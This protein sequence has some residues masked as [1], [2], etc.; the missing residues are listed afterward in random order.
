MSYDRQM[1]APISFVAAALAMA[2]GLSGVSASGVVPVRSDL[3]L[4]IYA[5]PDRLVRLPDGRK[6]NVHC[7][8]SGSPTVILTA[9][10]G[11]WSFDWHKVQPALAHYA[12]V[13]SWDRA[14][15][16]YSDAPQSPETS[17]TAE[18]DL[19]DWL[20]AGGVRPPYVIVGHSIGGIETRL[21]A[22]RNP[23]E[24]VG[25]V[26]V[27]PTVADQDTSLKR[28]APR[29]AA[30]V[31]DDR[32]IVRCK[33]DSG[34]RSPSRTHLSECDEPVP[35]EAPPAL[36]SVW[37]RLAD[38]PSGFAADLSMSHGLSAAQRELARLEQSLGNKPVEVLTAGTPPSVP[39]V[40][41]AQ[42]Q[43]WND[44]WRADHQR[45]ARL[46]SR[47]EEK[48]VS[49]STHV[50]EQEHPEAVIAAVRSVLER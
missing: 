35:S 47:G 26:L 2:A 20:H 22:A 33:R 45:I 9:G 7:T 15:F 39:S 28:I 6:I 50:I 46:S 5:H 1:Q 31:D 10:L 44:Y 13:C 24:V 18:R 34:R 21:F 48:L 14:G 30:I 3:T 11:Y 8:G 36:R 23:H 32:Q 49:G 25:M 40:I 12:R 16:G 19:E 37:Y 17:I 43:A 4:G 41:K 27:D 38:R 42:A 29:L